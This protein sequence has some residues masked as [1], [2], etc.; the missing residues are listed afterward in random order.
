MTR[1]A[2]VVVVGDGLAG[3][4]AALAAARAD[5]AATVRVVAA[6]DSSLRAASGLVDVLGY[7]PDGSG[8]VTDPFIALGELPPEHP[9]SVVGESAL[10]EG[11]ALF[12]EVT[13]DAYA[14]GHTDANALVPTYGGSVKPT[15]R[16]PAVVAPGL[17]TRPEEMLVAGFERLAA[18]DAHLTADLL[19]MLDV[20]FPTTGV[21]V[22]LPEAIT[23]TPAAPRF[24]AALDDNPDVHHRGEVRPL[25]AAL[26]EDL[27]ELRGSQD[28]VGL[29]AV[30]GRTAT[31]D[32]VER[33]EAR[34]SVPVFEIPMGPPSVPGQRLEAQLQEALQ[35]HGV[36]YHPDTRITDVR[37][38][39]GTVTAVV[40]GGEEPDHFAASGV[41]LAT[42]GLVGGGVGA[43]REAVREP[44]FDC[45]VAH[46]PDRYD[47]F[48][49][50]AF[51]DHRFARFG[52]DVDA[53][54][55]PLTANGSPEY[56][57]LHAAGA[58]LGGY[59]FA[60]EKSGAGVSLATGYV[61]GTRAVEDA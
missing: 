6:G 32:I 3:C 2:D 53:A 25:R 35:A 10:R 45:H 14:G 20:P 22:E 54:C 28:R 38:D 50:E 44:V 17:A 23:D 49:D 31:A 43:D 16:Y 27:Y 47:W 30:L 59:D 5:P 9:Y 26:A 51:G 1:D 19:E 52:V 34:L 57:N 21:T 40:A 7:G 29:P 48:E 18:F 37:T 13:G 61:A 41:V 39:D 36:H 24:A 15:A 4:A 42:G 60:A 56:A 55:R 11:L 46:P 33:L 58:V 12:D 8:P